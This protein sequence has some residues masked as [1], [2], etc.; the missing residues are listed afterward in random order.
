VCQGTGLRAA[1]VVLLKQCEP[2]AGEGQQHVDAQDGQH[3]TNLAAVLQRKQ[4]DGIAAVRAVTAGAVVQT[5]TAA[6]S[7]E[8]LC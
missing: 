7:P 5:R 2:P 8:G 1:C 3:N 6:G 4:A